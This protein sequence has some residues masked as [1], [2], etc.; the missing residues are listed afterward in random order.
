[1][2]LVQEETEEGELQYVW[3][4][5]WV[6]SEE[7]LPSFGYPYI[8]E[9]PANSECRDGVLKMLNVRFYIDG[10]SQDCSNPIVNALKLPQSCNKTSICSF[11]A[12]V[13][14]HWEEPLY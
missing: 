8:C 9:K 5:V 12:F 2:A 10:L 13:A 6:G 4:G 14:T 1:M 7:Q 3:K 11:A